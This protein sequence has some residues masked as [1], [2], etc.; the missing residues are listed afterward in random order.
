MV[1]LA[2]SLVASALPH[3][4][5]HS[6]AI[7]AALD[8]LQVLGSV[9]YVAAHPDDENTRLL[10]WLARVKH[11]RATYLSLTRG[12]GGQNLLGSEQGELLGLIRTQ[13][14]LA[15]RGVDG[16]EQLFTRARDF[17][18]S[19]SS[20]ETLALWGKERALGD[21]VWAIR[22][23]RP[24]IVVTRFTPK[25]PNHGHHTASAI[26]A[27]EAFRAA[28]DPKR[29]PEQLATVDVWQP[30]RLLYNVSTW[31]LPPNTDLSSFQKVDVGA[32]LPL[33]GASVGEL[34]ARSRS[35][36][37]SQGFG[38]AAERGLILEYFQPLDGP[39]GPND[40]PFDAFD[41]SWARIPGAAGVPAQLDALT[42]A[43]DPHHPEASLP[44][45]AR[46]KAALD[47]LPK[48][49]PKAAE[50]VWL[51][52]K[53]AEVEALLL[54]CA[55]VA[56]EA[57]AFQL[58]ERLAAAAPGTQVPTTIT[59]LARL[60]GSVTRKKVRFPD[61]AVVSDAVAVA[62]NQPLALA[63]TLTVPKRRAT[64][65]AGVFRLEDAGWD[66]LATELGQ[67]ELSDATL[68]VEVE[69]DI[70]GAQVTARVPLRAAWVDPLEGERSTRLEVAPPVSVTF[71]RDAFMALGP[72]PVTVPVTVSALRD[73]TQ[74]TIALRVPDGW[75]VTP[76]AHA[77]GLPTRAT[78][79]GV[80]FT[81]TA[82]K[83]AARGV[84]RADVTVDGMT[85]PALSERR[86][87][88]AHVPTLTIR[89]PAEAALVPLELQGPRGT[90]GLIPGPGDRVGEALAAVG[91]TVTT[92]EPAT[93][94]F[95][96][97]DA[98]V[99]G[100]RA[101]NQTPELHAALPRLL[102]YVEGGGRLLV[103]YMTHNRLAPLKGPIGPYPLTIGQGRVTNENAAL[104]PKD[105]THPA[106][107]TPNRL[108]PA[109]FTGW[110][111]ERGLYFAETWDP[112]YAAVFSA[113]DPDEAPLDG[114]LL[115]ARHGRGVFVYTGLAFFRQ[116]PAGVPGAYRLFQNLLSL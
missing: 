92:L 77:L 7:A 60:T 81:V 10:T 111:Q 83:Q 20:A 71:E 45:L 6:G 99:I 8:R 109:D 51:A 16:A 31:F 93:A 32:F 18:Y 100:V 73:N 25:P 2:L 95:S 87:A 43:F 29:F 59:V 94:S 22:R 107:T 53:R 12:E 105:P 11:Y 68:S 17:G 98:I 63:H 103:Q 27:A 50:S 49:P 1:D 108:V 78:P 57:R 13:E 5:P 34:A 113:A 58:G 85:A 114:G 112:R 46:L 3:A 28:G 35:M 33:L 74:A 62:R 102:A 41:A 90:I 116:L 89:E 40:A 23:E 70:A 19:K 14:L 106:L 76:K 97:L 48:R 61:E 47:A 39:A 37:K 65:A 55:G 86:A 52:R 104:V 54:A 80:T 21:L 64:N 24:D 101:F 91:Y 72:Q 82:P 84:I 66:T 36:H 42:K 96:G 38:V 30:K 115:V 75:T 4:P 56:I 88:Y 26:L 15:A 9:L 44:G 110:V 67:P 79:Q 69:L